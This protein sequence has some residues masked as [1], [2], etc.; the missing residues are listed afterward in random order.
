MVT[1]T[2]GIRKKGIRAEKKIDKLDNEIEDLRK[3][4]KKIEKRI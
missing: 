3:I 1:I 4:R 2:L